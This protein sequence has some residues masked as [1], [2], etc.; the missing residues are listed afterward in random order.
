MTVV[1]GSKML[2][3]ADFLSP[4]PMCFE[5][6]VTLRKRQC[7]P[8]PSLKWYWLACTYLLSKS[9]QGSNRQDREQLIFIYLCV[10]CIHSSLIK[11][12]LAWFARNKQQYDTTYQNLAGKTKKNKHEGQSRKLLFKAAVFFCFVFFPQILFLREGVQVCVSKWILGPE[13]HSALTLYFYTHLRGY[14]AMS[15]Q[16]QRQVAHSH[17]IDMKA[18]FCKCYSTTVA[19]VTAGKYVIIF[20]RQTKNRFVFYWL[21]LVMLLCC[22]QFKWRRKV[23]LEQLDLFLWSWSLCPWY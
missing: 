18:A 13:T 23:D 6:R 21:W 11:T 7:Y 22:P 2:Y 4:I 15:S 12:K 10:Y 20:P 9:L 8:W 5:S 17:S 16:R 3:I 14:V 1:M 19:N